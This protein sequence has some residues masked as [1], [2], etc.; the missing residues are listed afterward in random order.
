[1][2]TAVILPAAGV[3]KRFAPGSAPGNAGDDPLAPGASKLEIDLGGRPVFLRAVELFTGRPNVGP[4][5]L[6]VNP[7]SI[8]EFKFKW[9]DALVLHGV[10]VV[11]G[12]RQER[13][14][15]VMLALEAVPDDCTHVAVHDAA[16][17]LTS[18]KLIDRVL[19]AASRYSAVIPGAPV[20]ATL[21]RVTEEPDQRRD[22]DPIDAILGDA[23]RNVVT[24]QRVAQT[25]DRT[26]VVEV[27]TPQVFEINLL[28]RAY[29]QIRDGKVQGKGITDDAGLVEALAD[30]EHPVRVVEGEISNI[31][32]TR[33][34]DLKLAQAIFEML[35]GQAKKEQAR[36]RLFADDEE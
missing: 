24:V 9:G 13:W 36:K 18:P 25:L 35:H 33:P 2:K 20:N 22:V 4:I 6:A 8:S 34:D 21:K 5:I 29:A 30:P 26:N 11:P 23:G 7:D 15:T 10:K 1:M 3:G 27:Q 16:R 31:K 17:P 14:E 12:G 28:R 19:D 32:I